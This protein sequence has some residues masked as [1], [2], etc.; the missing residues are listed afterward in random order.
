MKSFLYFKIKF[1]KPCY[2]IAP[3]LVKYIKPSFYG[4][5]SYHFRRKK[6]KNSFLCIDFKVIPTNIFKISNFFNY[7]DIVPD[8]VASNHVYNKESLLP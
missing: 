5:P 7:K 1:K 8:Y 6:I 2:Q 3:K 4:K